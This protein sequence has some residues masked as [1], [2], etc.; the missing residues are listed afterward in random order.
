MGVIA[1]AV[2]SPLHDPRRLS[3]YVSE[4]LSR[5]RG[6]PFSGV[7]TEPA[8]LEALAAVVLVATG[9]T[10]HIVL[11]TA[12]R[13][14]LRYALL[15][16]HGSDNSLP[17]VMEVL[18][19][20]RKY[21]RADVVELEEVAGAATH[22]LAASRAYAS[23]LG[24]KLL[25]LGRP[26]PWLV[27][28]SGGEEEIRSKL[29]V[30]VEYADLGGLYEEYR[31]VPGDL[32]RSE[33]F[34]QLVGQAAAEDLEHSLRLYTAIRRMVAERSARAVSVRCFDLIG[35]LG[36]TGCL[37]VSKLLDA[38]IVAGCEAD[39][40][41][42]VTM[43]V[44]RE[45][46]GSPPW[47][48]NVVSVGGGIVELAH[49]TI[50][51]SLTQGFELTT[52]FESGRPVAVAGRVGEGAVVTVAKYDP[53]RNLV[54]AARGTVVEGS[55]RHPAR[56]RTQVAVRVPEGFAKRLLEDPLGAHVVV[57][58]VDVLRPLEFF[59]KIAGVGAEVYG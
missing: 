31:R 32:A 4:F 57:S 56:C 36:R 48:A 27:Y 18:P 23:L 42:A 5:V 7:L 39:V 17:A 14:R 55:P 43:M 10:E 25:V 40:P 2:A 54:R 51:T 41:S 58:F 13:S 35:T 45:L 37:A 52:H 59:A 49:C 38:G 20:L 34:S 30:E 24:S 19:E 8:G 53:K 29:G 15:V 22:L 33:E 44:L 11:E 47:I 28:S 26:S 12:R 9:G 3:S 50:A 6:V 21:V 16:Y 1:A 46:S